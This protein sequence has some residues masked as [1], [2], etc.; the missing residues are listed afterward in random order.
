VCGVI[1]V[2]GLGRADDA[3]RN[4]RLTASRWILWATSPG[5][6]AAWQEIADV[7]GHENI[8]QAGHVL[9]PVRRFS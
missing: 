2:D 3:S 1:V 6:V 8:E 4:L 9:R 7:V 5:I